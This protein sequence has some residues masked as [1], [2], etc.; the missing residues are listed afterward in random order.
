MPERNR[1]KGFDCLCQIN[2]EA[3]PCSTHCPQQGFA[4]APNLKTHAPVFT[5]DRGQVTRG[6]AALKQIAFPRITLI[7]VS[8]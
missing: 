8:I 7:H 6:R 3:P 5:P 2:V 1:A 4:I